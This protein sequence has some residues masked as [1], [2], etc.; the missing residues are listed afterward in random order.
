VSPNLVDIA[1]MCVHQRLINSLR[2]ELSSY[3]ADGKFITTIYEKHYSKFIFHN[4]IIAY[5]NKLI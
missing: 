2:W 1:Q 5:Y 4:E 3:N